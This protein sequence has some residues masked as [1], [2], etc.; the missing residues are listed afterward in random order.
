[1]S[2]HPP[3]HDPERSLARRIAVLMRVGTVIAAVLLVIAVVLLSL[4]QQQIGMA[5]AAAGCAT[6]VLLPVARLV[7]MARHFARGDRLFTLVSLLVLALV[8]TGTVTAL[9]ARPA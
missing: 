1:M 4:G 7:L 8:I 9:L 5:L 3:I 6:L 2:Q